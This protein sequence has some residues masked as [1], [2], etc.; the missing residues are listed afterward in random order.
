LQDVFADDGEGL[1]PLDDS[2]EDQIVPKFPFESLSSVS[3]G[4]PFRKLPRK[5]PKE[6]LNSL[7]SLSLDQEVEMISV[8]GVSIDTHVM[9]FCDLLKEKFYERSV[10][11]SHEGQFSDCMRGAKRDMHRFFRR[12]RAAG[13][14]FSDGVLPTVSKALIKIVEEP[15]LLCPSHEKKIAQCAIGAMPFIVYNSNQN[16]RIWG[17]LSSINSMSIDCFECSRSRTYFC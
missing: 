2:A 1:S 5:N 17:R 9:S 11:F 3:F 16:E 13:L 10:F 7:S 14:S 6:I 4:D 15:K 12:D 8:D